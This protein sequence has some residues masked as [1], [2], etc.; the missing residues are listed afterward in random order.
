[1]AWN[2]FVS[3][4]FSYLVT[5]HPSFQPLRSASGLLVP[6]SSVHTLTLTTKGNLEAAI[7][8]NMHVFGRW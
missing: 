3:G 6:I 7:D 8:L 5:I 2:F 4:F 1:M